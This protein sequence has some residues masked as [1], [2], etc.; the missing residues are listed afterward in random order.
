[1]ETLAESS[2]SKQN[3][4]SY[5]HPM[6]S[7]LFMLVVLSLSTCQDISTSLEQQ[8]TSL[9]GEPLIPNPPCPELLD[10]LADRE[11]AHEQDQQVA[12][13]QGVDRDLY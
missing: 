3:A 6:R 11:T 12:V 13:S 10:K 4:F 9:L 2:W 5:F 8:G 7:I 1:M